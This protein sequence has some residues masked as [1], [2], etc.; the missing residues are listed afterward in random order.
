[1]SFSDLSAIPAFRS[2]FESPEQLAASGAVL[3]GFF[4]E[5][6]R[7]VPWDL[8]RGASSTNPIIRIDS[9]N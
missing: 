7:G 9:S 2:E 4:Q 5:A 1:M 6:L 8:R 3:V